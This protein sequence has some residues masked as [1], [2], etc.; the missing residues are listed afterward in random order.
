M[1][2]GLTNGSNSIF[3]LFSTTLPSSLPTMPVST[4]QS[5]LSFCSKTL[6]I[7]C[8]SCLRIH[9]ISILSK[10][11]SPISKNADNSLLQIPLSIKLLHR[12]FLIWNDYKTPFESG[13][14]S[15]FNKYVLSIIFEEKPAHTFNGAASE[16]ADYITSRKYGA[17]AP[18]PSENPRSL[19]EG[20]LGVV[21]DYVWTFINRP[22]SPPR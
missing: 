5:Q 18:F 13:P 8:C 19:L 16:I 14:T 11:T 22:C 17:W 2:I 7:F 3:S 15:K 6:P 20:R 10:T 12:M 4:K 9:P 21:F 1:P